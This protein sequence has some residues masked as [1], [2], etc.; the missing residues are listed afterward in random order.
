MV[1][2]YTLTESLEFLEL[3]KREKTFSVEE[4]VLGRCTEKALMNAVRRRSHS[5]ILRLL[6]SGLDPRRIPDA[7]LSSAKEL[8]RTIK[9]AVELWEKGKLTPHGCSGVDNEDK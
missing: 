6:A 5:D 7:H 9:L 2:E 4:I 8:Q 3:L 1:E